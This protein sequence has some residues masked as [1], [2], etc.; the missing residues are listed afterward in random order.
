V[1]T[2][3]QAS[4]L[5][6][7]AYVIST[8]ANEGNSALGLGFFPVFATL[9]NLATS[10]VATTWRP[11]LYKVAGTVLHRLGSYLLNSQ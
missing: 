10:A 2:Q 4:S 1:S 6:S 8:I 7:G 11:L 9:A 3:P 5:Q